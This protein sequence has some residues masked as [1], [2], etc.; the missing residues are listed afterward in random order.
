VGDGRCLERELAQGVVSLDPTY[1]EILIRTGT[2]EQRAQATKMEWFVKRHHLSLVTLLLANAT[3]NE[4][5]PIFLD[6]IVDPVTAIVISVTALLIFGEI[7]PSAVFTGPAQ[8]RIASSLSPFLWVLCIAFYPISYPISL[9]LDV[10]LGDDHGTRYRRDELKEFIRLHGSGGAS[11][12]TPKSKIQ[13]KGGSDRDSFEPL[14]S[15]ASSTSK[16]YG[17]SGN[18][19]NTDSGPTKPMNRF[20]ALLGGGSGAK[21]TAKSAAPGTNIPHEIDDQ[22]VGMFFVAKPNS[23]RKMPRPALKRG[24]SAL[25]IL[26]DISAQSAHKAVSGGAESDGEAESD[27]H[28]ESHA[29]IKDEVTMLEGV[30]E[31]SKKTT[32]DVFT[33]IDRVFFLETTD[34]MDRRIMDAIVHSGFSRIPVMEPGNRNAIR[35]YILVKMLIALD[36]QD[37]TP[38][39]SL[40]LFRG[41]TIHPEV[42]LF[43]ALNAFQTGRSHLAFVTEQDDILARCL[44]SGER[45][46]DDVEVLGILTI[47]D[48]LEAIINEEIEDEG[49]Y[50]TSTGGFPTFLHALRRTKLLGDAAVKPGSTVDPDV[51]LLLSRDRSSQNVLDTSAAVTLVPSTGGNLT[52]PLVVPVS[53]ASPTM[54]GTPKPVKQEV[55]DDIDVPVAAASRPKG[56]GLKR[57][58]SKDARSLLGK[59]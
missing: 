23:S 22:T 15:A 30:L 21:A 54:R 16:G 4:C 3:A 9:L 33:P 19:L 51:K 59:E 56:Y 12:K 49:D 53:A 27:G 28:A 36:P 1:V 14:A 52:A 46:P 20:R 34:K 43:A 17:S 38:V 37:E 5:L 50:L 47:E 8:L 29:L 6:T 10:W 18:S 11:H 26:P 25:R 48:V 44:E 45:P 41:L 55:F 42:S 32:R 31:L 2:P 35:G 57:E 13:S 24:E 39:S 7:V 58:P 40:H